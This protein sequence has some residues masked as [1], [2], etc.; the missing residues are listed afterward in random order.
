VWVVKTQ[1]NEIKRNPSNNKEF[2]LCFLSNIK[3]SNGSL[4]TRKLN[5]VAKFEPSPLKGKTLPDMLPSNFSYTD[6]VAGV[7][8]G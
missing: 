5:I 8:F 7:D 6:S 3:N 2:S 4:S 1:N